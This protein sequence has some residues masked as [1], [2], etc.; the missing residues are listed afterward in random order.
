MRRCGTVAALFGVAL[1]WCAYAM[2]SLVICIVFALPFL[3]M[4]LLDKLLGEHRHAPDTPVE[5][6]H[7]SEPV[8]LSV[9]RAA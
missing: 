4:Y 6:P 8:P 5:P 1:A 2:V 3:V 9:S 7:R